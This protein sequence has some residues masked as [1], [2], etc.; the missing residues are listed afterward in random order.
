MEE[1]AEHVQVIWLLWQWK[2]FSSLN[3]DFLLGYGS[4]GGPREISRLHTATVLH[5]T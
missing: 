4:F 1:M 3:P 2:I 5:S